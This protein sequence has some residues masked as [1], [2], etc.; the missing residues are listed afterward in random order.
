M[1]RVEIQN[2]SKVFTGPNGQTVRAVQHASLVVAHRELVVLVGP[3]GAGKT[4]LLRLI[5]GLDTATD[6][7]I[8]IDGQVMNDVEPKDRDIAMVFQNSAL[9]PHLTA[10]QN[11]AFGLKLRKCPPSLIAQRV[12]DAAEMLGI[13]GCLDRKPAALSGGERQR[14]ALGRAIVRQPKVFLFDEPLSNLDVRWREQLRRE[15]QRLHQQLEATMIYVT[16]D[17]VEALTMGD[18]VAVLKDGLVQQVANPL[19]LYRQP[20]NLFVAGFIGSPPM[21]VLR[22]VLDARESAVWFE[23]PV[24]VKSA[25]RTRLPLTSE[26][27]EKLAGWIGRAVVLGL[28]PEHVLCGAAAEGPVA[29]GRIEGVEMTGPE[30][31]LR[32]QVSDQSWAARVPFGATWKVGEHLRVRLDI[33]QARCKVWV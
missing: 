1:A 14:V 12:R 22:G 27:A 28:R 19:T 13:M 4:T 20:A 23:A 18:R 33:A 21:N 16:H 30:T 7:I 5:A 25:M 31:F 29:T 26:Q 8:A 24:P 15:I 6:G 2:L 11:M 10:Y 17:Q 3:S 32:V 9:Y